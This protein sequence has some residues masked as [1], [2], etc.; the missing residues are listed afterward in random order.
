MQTREGWTWY[1]RVS[2][3]ATETLWYNTQ[4]HVCWYEVWL[5]IQGSL[6]LN[7]RLQWWKFGVSQTV[8]DVH[9]VLCTWKYMYIANYIASTK[10]GEKTT[11]TNKTYNTDKMHRYLLPI[12]VH[13]NVCTSKREY[14][15]CTLH[16]HVMYKFPCNVCTSKGK[17]KHSKQSANS[18]ESWVLARWAP[19]SQVVDTCSSIDDSLNKV[20]RSILASLQVSSR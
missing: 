16:G 5:V 8:S 14:T 3:L 17:V 20:P 18:T 9:N 15:Q 6:G 13:V 4:A 10:E 2:V 11:L 1:S 7:S 12:H 19:A